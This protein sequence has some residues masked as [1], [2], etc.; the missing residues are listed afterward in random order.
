M[1]L[2]INIFGFICVARLWSGD[3]IGSLLVAL[4]TAAGVVTLVWA[5][6]IDLSGSREPYLGAIHNPLWALLFAVQIARDYRQRGDR[7][8]ASQQRFRAIFDQTFQFIGLMSVEGTLLEVNQTAL[9]FAGIRAEDVIGKPF[10][11]TAWWM[12]RYR[13]ARHDRPG[14]RRGLRA[15]Y[16]RIKVVYTSGYTSDSINHTVLDHLVTFIAK[17][18]TAMD[19]TSKVREALDRS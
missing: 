3:R 18:F 14:A 6:R 10:W 9:T 17:P 4:A 1:S 13:D 12:H 7:L 16:P 19:F 5:V 2:S 11:E 15:R 8:A